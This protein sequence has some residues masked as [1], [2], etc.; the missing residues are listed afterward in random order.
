MNTANTLEGHAVAVTTDGP[1]GLV[2]LSDIGPGWADESPLP[3]DIAAQTT[4]AAEH[5]TGV[6]STRG[7]SW[8]NV[9]KM[10]VYVT[11]ISELSTVRSVLADQFGRDWAPAVTYVQ[12]DNLHAPGARLNLDVIAAG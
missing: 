3:T 2:F 7:L 6:L 5:L 12:V 1:A 11:D 4:R 10:L 8:H 9:A